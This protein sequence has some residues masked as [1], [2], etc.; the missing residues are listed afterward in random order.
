MP[1][2]PSFCVLIRQFRGRPFNLPSGGTGVSYT[3]KDQHRHKSRRN[4]KLQDY[5]HLTHCYILNLLFSFQ[6]RGWK[7]ATPN[8]FNQLHFHLIETK[9]DD[10]LDCVAAGWQ[11]STRAP[12]SPTFFIVGSMTGKLGNGATSTAAD[13]TNILQHVSTG[14]LI[15]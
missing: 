8:F 14:S 3:T 13:T 6:F 2:A 15:W 7:E 9:L 4:T 12:D 1:I 11:S 5:I 10:H